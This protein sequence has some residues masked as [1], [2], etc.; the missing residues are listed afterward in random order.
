MTKKVKIPPSVAEQALVRLMRVGDRLWRASDERFG[1]WGLTDNHYNVLRILNGSG[2]PIS[3]AEISRKMLSSRANVTKLLDM[4]E[5][6]KLVRRLSCEDRR[7]NLVELTDEGA[8]FVEETAAEVIGFANEEMRTLT[9][10]EQKAL[11][12]LLGKLLGE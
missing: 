7:V 3:Q 2:E 6:R 12:K 10:E 11:F 4:L 9:R 1:R 8:K 5:A